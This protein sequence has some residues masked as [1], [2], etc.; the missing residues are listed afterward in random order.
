MYATSERHWVLD[1]FTSNNSSIIPGNPNFKLIYEQTLCRNKK[2][3]GQGKKLK[4]TNIPGCD[5][6]SQEIFFLHLLLSRRSI[7]LLSI[8]WKGKKILKNWK[9]AFILWINKNED[10]K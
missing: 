6:I 8:I 2:L 10:A 4:L 1:T 3:K 7:K 5:G 9:A